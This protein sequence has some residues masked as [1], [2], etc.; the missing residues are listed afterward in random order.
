MAHPLRKVVSAGQKATPGGLCNAGV[1]GGGCAIGPPLPFPEYAGHGKESTNALSPGQQHTDTENLDC[2]PPVRFLDATE[3]FWHAF[4]RLGNLAIVNCISVDSTHPI[5]LETLKEAS[6]LVARRHQALR[7]V[8]RLTDTNSTT[9]QRANGDHHP[10]VAHQ[11]HHEL[12]KRRGSDDLLSEDSSAGGS[13]EAFPSARSFCTA[14]SCR[15]S[16]NSSGER[17]S[18]SSDGRR[19]VWGW[20]NRRSASEFGKR[21]TSNGAENSSV[22][23]SSCTSCRG[24]SNDCGSKQTGAAGLSPPCSCRKRS[25]LKFTFHERL[26]GPIVDV[27]YA[28]VN[29]SLSS[30]GLTWQQKHSEGTQLDLGLLEEYPWMKA[31]AWEQK[32]P[33]DCE[34]GP[35]WRLRLVPSEKM[36]FVAPHG[37][38][39]PAVSQAVSGLK[40]PATSP[41]YMQDNLCELPVGTVNKGNGAGRRFRT[42]IIGVFHHSTIDGL[43]RK[44]FWDEILRAIIVISNAKIY[45]D[46]ASRVKALTEA[47]AITSRSSTH[48]RQ[49]TL[50]SEPR[51]HQQG[52]MQLVSNSTAAMQT[53]LT[54]Q[55]YRWRRGS[56]SNT[57]TTR[58]SGTVY[59]RRC[60]A[61]S[62]N[63]GEFPI[64]GKDCSGDP[65][66]SPSASNWCYYRRLSAV[67]AGSVDSSAAYLSESPPQSTNYL[68]ELQ[69]RPPETIL[70]PALNELFPVSP[71]VTLLRPLMC[72]GYGIHV[73]MYMLERELMKALRN[74]FAA[75]YPSKRFRASGSEYKAYNQAAKAAIAAKSSPNQQ[76]NRTTR[77]A[78]LR[79]QGDGELPFHKS[80]PEECKTSGDVA[81]T[82]V[83]TLRLSEDLTAGL[84]SACRER[85]M[86]MNGLITTAAAV[87]LSRMLW[88]RQQVMQQHCL[89]AELSRVAA[90]ANGAQC[91]PPQQQSL[92]SSAAVQQNS[93]HFPSAPDT[94]TPF[95]G[96]V[97]HGSKEG[98]LPSVLESSPASSELDSG[99]AATA[100]GGQS[101][102][103]CDTCSSIHSKGPVVSPQNTLTPFESP[104][105]PVISSGSLDRLPSVQDILQTPVPGACHSSK[106]ETGTTLQRSAASGK[107]AVSLRSGWSVS[108]VK[109]MLQQLTLRSPVS[110]EGLPGESNRQFIRHKGPVY[111]YSLQ[112]IS[113]RRWL[114]KWLQERKRQPQTPARGRKRIPGDDKQFEEFLLQYLAV[115]MRSHR[116]SRALAAI[117]AASV[118]LGASTG[119]PSPSLHLLSPRQPSNLPGGRTG[120]S[121]RSASSS[122]SRCTAQRRQQGHP[123]EFGSDRR[124][125]SEAFSNEAEKKRCDGSTSAANIALTVNTAEVLQRHRKACATE[126]IAGSPCSSKG[127]VFNK[128]AEGFVETT[129]HSSLST[130]SSLHAVSA[131]SLDDTVVRSSIHSL[132]KSNSRASC[133]RRLHDHR[134]SV[135][136]RIT[137]G[138]RLITQWIWGSSKRCTT[139][140]GSDDQPEQTKA[141]PY[142]LGSYAFLMPL[143]LRVPAE[144][145]GRADAVWALGKACTEA[146]HRI[147]S[148]PSSSFAF[149]NF[150]LISSFVEEVRGE[151]ECLQPF[152]N[153]AF[154]RP[155][156]FLISNGGVWAANSLNRFSAKIHAQLREAP[157]RHLRL[158]HRVIQHQMVLQQR[159]SKKPML[160]PL[161]AQHS[162]GG[163]AADAALKSKRQHGSRRTACSSKCS[164]RANDQMTVS[165]VLAATAL[166]VSG[167]HVAAADGKLSS[168]VM[169]PS[170]QMP[171]VQHQ[172][173]VEKENASGLECLAGGLEELMASLEPFDISVDS[174]WSIVS[175]HNT[176]LNYFAHNCVTVNGKM[177]WSLQYHSNL[178]SR[179]IA[180]LYASNILEVLQEAY[181]LHVQE[182]VKQRGQQH[183]QENESPS[184]STQPGETGTF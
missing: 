85:K 150:Q 4:Q 92:W 106:E 102:T 60:S 47:T 67:S 44:E 81:L 3:C 15:S 182:K 146:V 181:E 151:L 129:G 184:A 40:R 2:L 114:D 7:L 143:K 32:T 132:A 179:E 77:K 11:N 174:S 41:V 6:I 157:E 101:P 169:F 100:A 75:Y 162:C 164:G 130:S 80:H 65:F 16:S 27:K 103:S 79:E 50:S 31:M 168:H 155:S 170:G 48:F 121:S 149:F 108:H 72:A 123:N 109:E 22:R 37:N 12:D 23:S 34:H 66:E 45:A 69:L 54:S 138:L 139:E 172:Q 159:H 110:G 84:I 24:A 158:L 93:T 98:Y 175:Q 178:T 165:P 42:H 1:S 152:R 99:K 153:D 36:P 154:A 116:C 120:S 30:A 117:A 133:S 183:S 49:H 156:A 140:E 118:A 128:A 122:G 38:S 83:V 136:S 73:R 113:G 55:T 104:S 89:L 144:C 25:N 35:L 5:E 10:L 125:G 124:P 111:I 163:G 91:W 17:S 57:N 14:A 51:L 29:N 62:P 74:P 148:L 46:Y 115:S 70:P 145:N 166:Y 177:N 112:A 21:G 127:S 63:A 86:T 105:T 173:P 90:A 68:P 126:K 142:G 56:S 176:G 8:I 9:K 61:G 82:G 18:I 94:G 87:A 167:T 131:A 88:R 135:A 141:P 171:D 52:S 161:P 26:G 58:S 19:G 147:V 95:A 76:A 64:R 78:P 160:P 96:A 137:R 97:A 20:K 59:L 107:S 28:T 180:A 134:R 13:A 33:L 53:P 119:P 71:C 43:S 39:M